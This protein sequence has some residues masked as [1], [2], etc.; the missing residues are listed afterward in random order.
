MDFVVSL[1]SYNIFYEVAKCG[2]ITRASEKLF[3]SQPAVSQSIK[4]LEDCLGEKLFIRSRLGMELTIVGKRIFDKVERGLKSLASVN[5]IVSEEKGLLTGEINIGAGSNITRKVLCKPL[6]NFSYDYPNILVSINEG[7]QNQMIEQLKR[8]D[9][10]FV[11]TQKSENIPL[12]YVSFFTTKYCFVS[13]FDS[14]AKK[15]ITLNEGSYICSIFEEF[16]NKNNFNDVPIM[17]VSGYMTCLE[18]ALL[19]AGTTLVPDYLAE[20]FLKEGKIK[21]VYT[22][23]QLPEIT[24]VAYYNKEF[25]TSADKKFLEYL[26]EKKEA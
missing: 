8:G 7:M 6:A 16:I 26:T 12:D 5:T 21:K 23:Y 25:L 17:R 18:M 9:L 20:E 11:I 2:N 15:F 22:D 3:I 4:K 1:D 13:S 19:G 14:D 24:F 10:D